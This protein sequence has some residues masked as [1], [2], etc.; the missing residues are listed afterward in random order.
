MQMLKQ[1]SAGVAI[2]IR[3]A[4]LRVHAHQG[5]AFGAKRKRFSCL[6]LR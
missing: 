1:R 4:A 3:V 2:I 6:F 5:S